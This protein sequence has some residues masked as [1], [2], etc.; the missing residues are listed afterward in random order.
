MFCFIVLISKN[1]IVRYLIVLYI[2]WKKVLQD[3]LKHGKFCPLFEEKSLQA[4]C[5]TE[6]KNV[7]KCK[8][9]LEISFCSLQKTI[10]LFLDSKRDQVLISVECCCFRD[11]RL[12]ISP[13]QGA[14]QII[15]DT[16][17]AYF[18]LPSPMC[19]LVTLTQT[20]V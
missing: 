18:R 20:P 1:Q 17:L 6:D 12:F 13:P 19:H 4:R 14:I 11:N 5:R 7:I 9:C 2:P 15:R 10:C 16:F 3:W 8:H